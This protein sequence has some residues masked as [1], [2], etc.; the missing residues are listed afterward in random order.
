MSALK[1]RIAD[2]DWQ[3]VVNFSFVS[4]RLDREL[5]GGLEP[6]VLRNPIAEHL[7]VMRTTLWT[8]LLGTV[9][10]NV[11]RKATRVRVFEVGKVFARDPS[12]SGGPLA[13]AGIAQPLRVAGLAW[14]PAL[15][16]QW[17]AATRA[18]DFFDVKADLQALLDPFELRC[19]S[20][21]HPA[22]HPGRSARL[23]VAGQPAGWLGA[24]HPL[25]QQRQGLSGD[26]P[27]L[28]ELDAELML[29]RPVP[30]YRETSKFP[31]VQRDLA[32]VVDADVPAQ[33][34]LDEI[35]SECAS[36]PLLATVRSVEI[37]DEY[38]GKG[39]EN[40]EKSLAFRFLLQDTRRTLNDDEVESASR[41]VVA[42]L[43]RSLGARLRA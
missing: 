24:L 7:D 21:E 35:H 8:G 20:A 23:L 16:E 27:V 6:V 32:F 15:S 1:R 12:A 34:L 9:L 29:R 10:H 30:V 42:R 2:R 31:A 22:L 33:A 36:N 19:E 13:V 39:L 37:F 11:N 18:V 38:R 4:G 25:L 17:G 5:S 43:E 3:E 40:K 14:G 26:A 28:W 41:A